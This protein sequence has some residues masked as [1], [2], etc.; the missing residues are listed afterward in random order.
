[1][2]RTTWIQEHTFNNR[3]Y[4]KWS[5]ENRECV[6]ASE[7]QVRRVMRHETKKIDIT[8]TH[9]LTITD[10]KPCT[11][12]QINLVTLDA[13]NTVVQNISKVEE[14]LYVNPGQVDHINYVKHKNSVMLHWQPPIFGRNCLKNYTIRYAKKVGHT[15]GNW[16][17]HTIPADDF[18]RLE[19]EGLSS[20]ER[21]VFTISSNSVQASADTTEE[22]DTDFDTPG[23]VSNVR[24]EHISP[25]NVT[26]RWD[27]PDKNPGCVAAYCARIPEDSL[28]WA[29]TEELHMTL[30]NLQPCN[31]YTVL[32]V[33]RDTGNRLGEATEKS[34]RTLEDNPS[35]VQN[36]VSTGTETYLRVDWNP[37]KY[38]AFCVKHY[39]YAVWYTEHTSHNAYDNH[40]DDTFVIFNDLIACTGYTIQIIPVGY[41]ETIEG[42]PK[43]HSFV[44]QPRGG[45]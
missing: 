26:V 40:T 20:C 4:L 15:S 45:F 42:Q 22:F 29:C 2:P 33:V 25:V 34:F 27:P 18:N 1:V 31:N 44:S 19:L 36:I 9:E 41:N 16:I 39:R 10:L 32:I 24:I 30:E 38:G 6:K 21:Y 12:Y 11:K 17:E 5:T 8:K 13:N 7:I 35:M 23:Q 14:T 3:I 43:M 37:P 28:Q